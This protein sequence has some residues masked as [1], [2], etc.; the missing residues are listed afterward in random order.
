MQKSFEKQ[1]KNHLFQRD[2]FVDWAS[3]A[4]LKF[5]RKNC[6]AVANPVL[7]LRYPREY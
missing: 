2:I 4:E 1:R 7:T 6:I 5:I 3:Q